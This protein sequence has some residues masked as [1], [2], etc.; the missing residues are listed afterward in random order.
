MTSRPA[1]LV[2]P[3]DFRVPVSLVLVFLEIL[4]GRQLGR[5][6]VRSRRIRVFCFPVVSDVVDIVRLRRSRPTKDSL[7]AFAVSVHALL[8]L[9][10]LPPCQCL[11]FYELK[12]AQ[13]A[14]ST[15][16]V[17]SCYYPHTCICSSD[18]R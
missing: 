2:S 10:P 11:F 16:V 17:E 4:I 14:E 7:S 9:P 3:W 8:P 13:E 15:A 18:C 12:V 6:R 1:L 5:I